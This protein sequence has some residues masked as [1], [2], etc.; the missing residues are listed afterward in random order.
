MGQVARNALKGYTFQHYIFVLFLA[1]M[2][3]ERKIKKIESETIIE[4]NFD[5][6]YIEG[7]EKYRI[8]VKNYPEVTLADINISKGSV[9]IKGN[10]NKYNKDEKNVVIINT[11]KIDTDSDFM[12]I[13]ATEVNGVIIIPLTPV[14]VQN[15]L[16]DMFSTEVREV[17][18]IHFAFLR[19]TSSN[20]GVNVKDLPKLIR[21]STDLSDRTILLREP[22]YNIERGILW[23]Y[24]KP[25]VGKSHYV[26]ELIS[27][28]NDAI[29]YRFWT[30]AQDENLMRRL[31]FDMFLKDVAVAVFNSPRSFSIDELV[32]EIIRQDK[33]L[34]IDGL[35]HV[36]N[37]YPIELKRYKDFFENLKDARVIIL[38]RPLAMKCNWKSIELD[39]WRYDE[40]ELYLAMEHDINEYHVV[41]KIYEVSNG[42]PII[43]FF[44]AEH[45]KIYKEINIILEIK[46]LSQYYNILLEGVNTK[47]L[48]S[49]FATNNSFFTESEISS[50]LKSSYVVG[51][52][53]EFI[54]AYPYLFEIVLNRISLIHDS[55]NTYLRDELE[56]YFDIKNEVNEFVQDSLLGGKVNFM[57]RLSSFEFSEE[58]YKK[59]LFKYSQFDKLSIILDSTLDYNSVTAF[60]NQLQKLLEQREGVLDIYNYYSFALIYQMV[61][62]ND[63]IGYDGLL[64]QLLRYMKS[65]FKIEEEIF[66][67]GILWNTYIT[68]KLQNESIYKKY[69]SDNQY[70]SNEV[71]KL[72]EIVYDENCYFEVR[73]DKADYKVTLEKLNDN[74]IYEFDKQDILIRHLIRVW[75]NQEQGDMFFDILDDYMNYNIGSSVKKLI[76]IIKEYDIDER[77][78]NRILSSAKY[79][80]SEIGELGEFN[81]FRDKNLMDVIK[82]IA[83]NGSFQVADYVKSFIRLANYEGRNIDIYSINRLWIM[84]YNRKDYSVST[85]DSSLIVFE[86]FGFIEE[87]KSIDVIRKVMS[88]SEKGI[89][90]LLS[91]YINSK[92]ELFIYK[93]EQWGVFDDNKYSV[94][95]FDLMPEKINNINI[96]YIDKRMDELFLY[97]RYGKTIEYYIIEYALKSKYSEL[98]IEMIEY[99]GY[100]IFG[101]IEDEETKKMIIASGIELIEDKKED[102]EKYVPFNH[103]CIHESDKDYIINNGIGY[104]EVSRYPDGWYSCF[105]FVDIYSI[106]NLDEI[107]A[108]Y[109]K[110]IHNSMFSRVSDGEYIG[111][112]NFLLG[113]VPEFLK[114][115]NLDINWNRMYEVYKCFLRESLIYDLD[116]NM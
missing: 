75:T 56:N 24:G 17:Q 97:H 79:Q 102:K 1:K 111:N 54:R 104:L 53:K 100:K 10:Y 67:S 89:R 19:I 106:Y 90:N 18:I 69:L 60:Y 57:A 37:Y 23:I 87:L 105:P 108:N 114:K 28:Y 32:E 4:S 61:T 74:S 71:Y 27:K 77:W 26:S 33:I 91:N 43:T 94:D 11:N 80:L 30:G 55:F 70:D 98:I 46:S 36:E 22:I 93:L 25:G 110:I 92:N 103:G 86:K 51:A 29:V 81:L 68:L 58:F 47:S 82:E 3:V 14:A 44:L 99:Y 59:I 42:Y 6:L 12:G 72:Y 107:K 39:N 62:R 38:S 109:L 21:M 35:D 8:Q 15:L 40:T 85:L 2:D 63:L 78:A 5:D 84:Y 13:P 115:Y 76:D 96:K 45:Y 31:Q 48:L 16:D 41:K 49:I 20:F 88:Q 112:W 52:L 50:I 34:I 64:Y 95:I 116:E 65:N 101:I 83:P 9:K 7:V 73:K 113:H 66:S